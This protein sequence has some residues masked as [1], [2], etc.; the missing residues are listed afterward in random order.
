MKS[1]TSLIRAAIFS[2]NAALPASRW[3][4]RA[5]SCERAIPPPVD[6]Q[7]PLGAAKDARAH[8]KESNAALIR[9]RPWH[10]CSAGWRGPVSSRLSE[11]FFP[12][13]CAIFVRKHSSSCS[14][15]AANVISANLRSLATRTTFSRQFF[16][17]ESGSFPS[18]GKCAR[19]SE[20]ASTEA[21]GKSAM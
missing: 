9:S 8:P 6:N 2:R 14:E 4:D 5:S 11:F 21:R 3:P 18:H 1:S 13:S 12:R 20:S 7:P 16:S 17:V 19:K 10:R 15:V